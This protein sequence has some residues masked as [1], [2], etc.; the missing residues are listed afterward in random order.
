MMFDF[1]TDLRQGNRFRIFR[2][3]YRMGIS[4]GNR[5]AVN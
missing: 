5:N 3:N 2:E 4:D 1:R